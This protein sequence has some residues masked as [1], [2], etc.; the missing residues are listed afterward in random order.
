MVR[1]CRVIHA[2]GY[3]H[4]QDEVL[5]AQV[6]SFP[7][8]FEIEASVRGK[9]SLRILTPV[10]AP[11]HVARRDVQF[12][13]RFASRPVPD[14]CLARHELSF[15]DRRNRLID[16]GTIVDH[17]FARTVSQRYDRVHGLQHG[18]VDLI[19]MHRDIDHAGQ[20]L[21]ANERGRVPF[22]WK[23]MVRFI[24]QNPVRPTG[25]GPQFLK[26]WEQA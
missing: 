16:G 25:L 11:F 14:N 7:W 1:P 22:C 4:E 17:R 2:F 19:R 26:S 23:Q 24:H 21:G 6:E 15:W 9:F 13:G 18:P 3:L 12:K 8:S 5:R 20:H 10:S